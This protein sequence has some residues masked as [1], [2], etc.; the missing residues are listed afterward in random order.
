MPIVTKTHRTTH[1]D[2]STETVIEKQ[3]RDALGNVIRV[4]SRT[5]KKETKGA[6]VGPSNSDSR[7][8]TTINTSI[9]NG[10]PRSVTPAGPTSGSSPPPK[11]SSSRSP[12][13][14]KR[15]PNHTNADKPPVANL[16]LPDDNH[17]LVSDL[18]QATPRETEHPLIARLKQQQQKQREPQRPIVTKAQS[19]PN[20]AQSNSNLCRPD[21]AKRATSHSEHTSK[22]SPR[23]SPTRES[24]TTSI[25]SFLAR[26]LQKSDN[27]S[28]SSSSDN[29][30]G[31][32]RS[33]RPV[34]SS[35]QSLQKPSSFP[36]HSQTT[37]KAS[38]LQTAGTGDLASALS[39]AGLESLIGTFVA[40]GVETV[41]DARLLSDNDLLQL[42]LNMGQR[43]RF[44]QMLQSMPPH[45]RQRKSGPT[46]AD[47]KK[48]LQLF[49]GFDTDGNGEVDLQEF[50][51][52]LKKLNAYHGDFEARRFFDEGDLDGGGTLDRE[53]FVL[54]VHS[55][56]QSGS[57]GAQF[58]E[59]VHSGVGLLERLSRSAG[60]ALSRD[61][62]MNA[63]VTEHALKECK[64]YLNGFEWVSIDGARCSTEKCRLFWKVLVVD[65]QVCK[66]ILQF[67]CVKI[68]GELD[69]KLQASGV[70]GFVQQVRVGK[71]VEDAQRTFSLICHRYAHT[72]SHDKS[73]LE[74][75]HGI[76]F[77]HSFRK[78]SIVIASEQ[79]VQEVRQQLKEQYNTRKR[80]TS[81][82]SGVKPQGQVMRPPDDLGRQVALAA[83]NKTAGG[84]AMEIGMQVATVAC[85]IM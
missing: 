27:Q 12:P 47:R 80:Q 41:A 66:Q 79:S 42:G 83:L 37:T 9:Y 23:P 24:S 6:V 84:A 34:S 82:G 19:N 21:K 14:P 55:A 36:N 29:Q 57:L 18:T 75:R 39:K 26:E 78:A 28:S 38:T 74:S 33:D 68:L 56:V 50:I 13:P 35:T 60:I 2:G 62:V 51:A 31:N 53:E 77:I 11:P 1:R 30:T 15:K 76:S 64:R 17:T 7:P 20:V 48:Y 72:T 8:A 22:T 67:F 4:I 70:S 52:A 71:V 49:D 81:G 16:L 69:K 63:P 40:E 44:K 45:S 54:L 5:I 32:A 46:N 85:T 3:E 58:T 10:Q 73:Y 59:I 61:D 25:S 65:P 43:N